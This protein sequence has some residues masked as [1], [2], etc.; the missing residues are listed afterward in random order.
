MR[1]GTV[2]RNSARSRISPVNPPAWY[3]RNIATCDSHSCVRLNFLV[4]DSPGY[5]SGHMYVVHANVSGT[6]SLCCWTTYFPV[7]R[8]HHVSRSPDSVVNSDTSI[9]TARTT[10]AGF[11]HAGIGSVSQLGL[12]GSGGF[13]GTGAVR[14]EL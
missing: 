5:A 9:A 12:T 7:A 3:D 14:L 1:N 11:T 4:V 8:C 6:G 13:A 10:S 2:V